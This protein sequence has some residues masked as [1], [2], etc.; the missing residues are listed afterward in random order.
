M[1]KIIHPK[2]DTCLV[3]AHSRFGNLIKT[4]DNGYGPLWIYFTSTGVT[5]IIRAESFEKAY[6]CILDEILEPI[7]EEELPE[8]YGF[9]GDNAI[10]AFASACKDAIAKE[11]WDNLELQEGYQFQPNSTGTGI[12]P[13]DLSYEALEPL[14][15]DILKNHELKIKIQRDQ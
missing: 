8:A 10:E 12:V 7:P 6:E 11:N 1:S 4:Y 9:Y 2:D 14:T 13:V 5:G 3:S 15:I